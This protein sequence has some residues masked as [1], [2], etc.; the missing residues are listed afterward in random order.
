MDDDRDYELARRQEEVESEESKG[1]LV[2]GC[3]L[4]VLIA[5]GGATVLLWAGAG[6]EALGAWRVVLAVIGTIVSGALLELLRDNE[7]IGD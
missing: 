7:W 1:C 3:A 6:K 2:T 5:I 4:I